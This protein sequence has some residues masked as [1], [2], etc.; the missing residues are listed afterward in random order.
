MVVSYANAAFGY[1]GRVGRA[2]KR[3]VYL[4]N[5]KGML[6]VLVA[7]GHIAQEMRGNFDAAK[8]IYMFIYFFHMPMFAMV[9]G[10]LSKPKAGITAVKKYANA[11]LLPYFIFQFVFMVIKFL[12]IPVTFKELIRTALSPEYALWYLFCLFFWRLLLPY[13]MRLPYPL[14]LAF[15]IGLLSG[16]LPSYGAVFSSSRLFAFF[17]FYILGYTLYRKGWGL[18]AMADKV[19]ETGWLMTLCVIV[20]LLA[21]GGAVALN[22][23]FQEHFF[24]AYTYAELGNPV[25][26][27][28][29]A[30]SAAYASALLVGLSFILLLP[31][32]HS[33]ITRIGVYS[34][35]VYLLHSLILFVLAYA[36]WLQ[37][38]THPVYFAAAM[39][40]GLPLV[41]FL[42][43]PSVVRAT[44]V[45]VTGRRY[46]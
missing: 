22:G 27:S 28:F 30:R 6:M 13:F 8:Q 29:L 14:L 2:M 44:A 42:S 1:G 17:P 38:I 19:K 23:R 31:R 5:V 40:A 16:F 21:L 46:Q 25:W 10:Y 45:L 35:Y 7:L 15:I 26:V 12:F 39:A 3:S 32:S 41:Y 36:G 20:L 4:D 33:W 11:I 24:F 34:L 37:E 43:A 9:S 18:H